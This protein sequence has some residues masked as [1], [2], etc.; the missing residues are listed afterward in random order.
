MIRILGMATP[1]H[2]VQVRRGWDNIPVQSQ[3]LV[4]DPEASSVTK[5]IYP[6][7][8]RAINQSHD[9]YNWVGDT[10]GGKTVSDLYSLA[11]NDLS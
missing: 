8:R 6:S 7:L 9:A 10:L 2:Q 3:Q 11:R 1:A 5:N 4:L